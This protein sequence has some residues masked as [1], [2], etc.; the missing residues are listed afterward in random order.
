MEI[1]VPEEGCESGHHPEEGG[2]SSGA[3]CDL[4]EHLKPVVQDRQGGTSAGTMA[5]GQAPAAVL[6]STATATDLGPSGAP[7]VLDTLLHVPPLF[8]RSSVLRI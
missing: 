7:A 6:A 2:P 5:P 4:H 3:G 8:Q 1:R